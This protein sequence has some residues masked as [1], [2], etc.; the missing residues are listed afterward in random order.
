[1]EQ[2]ATIEENAL[3]AR[4]DGRVDDCTTIQWAGRENG[5][6]IVHWRDGHRSAFHSVWLRHSRYFPAFPDRAAGGERFVRPDRP[7]DV[8]PASVE[9]TDGGDLRV[10]W[11]PGG[12]VTDFGAAWLRGHCYSPAERARRRRPVVHWDGSISR[13]P[14]RLSYQRARGSDAGRL[15]LYRQVLDYGFAFLRGVP[16]QSGAVAEVG[17][18]FGLVR[19]SPYGDAAGDIRVENVRVDPELS[20]G[21]TM[22]DFQGPHTDTCWRQSISGL[23]FMHCLK[24]HDSGGESLLVD[25]FTVSERLRAADPEAFEL[26][27]TV[28]INY[29]SSVDNGDEWRSFGRVITCDADGN[30]VG[31]RFKD[32]SISW[33]DLP[34]DLIEPVYAALRS[35][36]VV[37]YDPALRLR[38]KLAPGDAV[39]IDNQRVLHGRAHFDPAVCERHMQHCSVDRDLFHNNYRRLARALGDDDWN[40]V[41]PWG[42]C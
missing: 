23:V 2:D 30:V 3:T 16:A 17:A 41:L 14:P 24:A 34:E 8:A 28:R 31:F 27:S 25:G 35:L 5:R 6:V 32:G 4:L 42:V 9:V 33:L 21:T 19:P 10:T 12:D 11:S 22:C 37:L 18:L 29:G 26:L 7:E 39:V 40:Q 20:V 13:S 38:R 1:M 36:E 15:A